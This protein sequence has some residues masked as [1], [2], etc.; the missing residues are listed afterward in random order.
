M[1]VQEPRETHKHLAGK[2]ESTVKVTY[3][4]PCKER[5]VLWWTLNESQNKIIIFCLILTEVQ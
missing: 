5:F 3:I 4:C 1:Q 2:V